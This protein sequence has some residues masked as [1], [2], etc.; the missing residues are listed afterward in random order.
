MSAPPVRRRGRVPHIAVVIPCYQVERHI[1]A[2]VAS[3][4]AEVRTIIA[5][6]D[7]SRDGT[8]AALARIADPRLVRFSHPANRG[9]GAAM[10]SGYRAALQ[11]GADVCVKMDGDGQMQ[12]EHL[13]RL[14][15]P[16]LGGAADYGKGNRFRD[17]EALGRMPRLRLVGNGV[18]SFL[19]KL[20]SGYWSIFDPTNG[21]TAIRADL[22]GRLNLERLDSRYFFETSMLI[23]LNI[24]G[25][26]VQDV[27]IPARYADEVSS[28]RIWRELLRFPPRL[29]HGLGRRFFWRYMIRDF[30]L[31]TLCVLAGIPLLLFGAVFGGYH[32]WRSI[33][34]GVPA[35]AG[36]TILA[37][38]PI[39]LGF[40]AMLTAVMLDVLYQP[41]RPLTWTDRAATRW[42]RRRRSRSDMVEEV[43]RGV[44][45]GASPRE[46]ERHRDRQV[47]A[48]GDE[49]PHEE[50]HDES[51]EGANEGARR[52]D[53]VSVEVLR[54]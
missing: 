42:R 46:E 31:L 38:L 41:A 32:W 44:E 7:G 12:A 28:L 35:T 9:V 29:L 26:V 45:L 34:T 8:A 40:Q 27:E 5:V 39:L 14:V 48:E 30:N 20:V 21:Y 52:G 24:Q 19:T 51:P 37:A 47:A 25:A 2:V 53:R 6:D 43:A 22:L 4:P 49:P 18:L 10:V 11:R 15:E 17:L 54:E 1:E 16:L 3:I 36:T 23:E 33:A 50:A 13:P